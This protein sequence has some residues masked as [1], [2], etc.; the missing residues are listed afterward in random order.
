MKNGA[1]RLFPMGERAISS[2]QIHKHSILEDWE[3][4]F[5]SLSQYFI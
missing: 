4:S 1:E 3:V 2:P 5:A